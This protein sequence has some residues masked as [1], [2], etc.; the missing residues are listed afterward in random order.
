LSNCKYL[1]KWAENFLCILMVIL[2]SFLV[3][4]MVQQERNGGE[5]PGF[6]DYKLMI[7]MSGSMKPAFDT[8]ALIAVKKVDPEGITAGEIITYR[9]GENT[10]RL[11]THRVVEVV[12]EK[13][14]IF[15]IT[16][17]DD[18]DTRDFSLIPT[19]NVVGKV[20]GAVPY[21]GYLAGLSGSK[22]GVLVFLI[23]PVLLA[24]IGEFR[25]VGQIFK[26]NEDCKAD[27]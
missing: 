22:M 12:H 20:T 6:G 11:I 4:L 25:A 3:Y 23:I 2:F 13:D 24:V 14:G 16:K 8:G 15:F 18:N 17:G 19:K 27:K 1:L 5:P 26:K 7:V 21:I 9:D 10:G